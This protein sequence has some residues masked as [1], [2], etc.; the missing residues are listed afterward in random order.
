MH[1]PTRQQLHDAL[2]SP[3]A[4]TL[5]PMARER[6][7]WITY[8]V[9]HDYSM[10]ET[11]VRFSIA[12]ATLRRWLERFDVHNLSHLEDRPSDHAPRTTAIAP[13]IIHL[14]RAY[15]QE[16]PLKGKEQISKHLRTEHG[17]DISASTV[18]RVIERECMYFADT[19]LHWSKRHRR[20]EWE[21]TQTDI[22]AHETV[23]NTPIPAPTACT[24]GWCRFRHSGWPILR[25]QI[26]FAS[27]L[28]HIVMIGLFAVTVLWE[29]SSRETETPLPASIIVASASLSS[30]R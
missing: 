26:A 30:F 20:R 8:F 7:R 16:Y 10:T 11:C 22:P 6:L 25:R 19:P 14:I 18:G 15:R 17:L 21:Q 28:V 4:A 23:P 29:R 12:R 24:C 13:E 2:R 1:L 9:E 3:E 27:V 5:S